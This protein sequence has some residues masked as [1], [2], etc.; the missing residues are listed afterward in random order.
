MRKAT[1]VAAINGR[2]QT[3]NRLLNDIPKV[4]LMAALVMFRLHLMSLFIIRPEQARQVD[5]PQR[6]KEFLQ[7]AVDVGRMLFVPLI[8]IDEWV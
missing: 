3:P 8:Q 6:I 2:S 1:I 4:T 7:R 5:S